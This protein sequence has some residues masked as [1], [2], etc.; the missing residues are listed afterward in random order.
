MVAQ[1]Y[2]SNAQHIQSDLQWLEKVIQQRYKTQQAKDK[3]M[4][5]PVPPPLK[6]DS[7]YKSITLEFKFTP[8]ERLV[9]VLALVPHVAPYFLDDVW[10]RIAKAGEPSH[11]KP[12]KAG[13]VPTVD[14]ALFLLAGDDLEQRFYF[15]Q[16]FD[17]ESLMRRSGMLMMENES[18][19]ISLLQQ[20]IRIS[21]DYLHLV[22][23]GKPYKPD[24]S[25]SFPAKRITT[26]R[27][28]D[29][30]VLNV[31]TLEQVMEIKSWITH[32]K[33]ILHEWELG[34]R[35]APGYKILFYGP[36]GTGKTFTAALLGRDTSVDVYRVDLSMVVSKY[37]G[38]TEKNLSRIFDSANNK[39]WILFFDEADALFGKRTELRD[40]HDRYANQ[41][42]AFLLQKIEDHNGVVILS[43]NMRANIDE[44]FTRRFQNAIYFPIPSKEERLRIWQK[45][46]S[47]KTTLQ[48]DI[49]LEQLSA[50]YEMSGGAIMNVVRYASL[51]AL[52]SKRNIIQLRDM[53]N[54]IAREFSKEGRT[55]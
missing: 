20:P 40:A 7:I 21:P 39:E 16:I 11:L 33:T 22:T 17:Q 19:D 50:R 55:I 45:G 4:K 38:E 54:G 29:D 25:T 13:T 23:D 49:S 53:V 51:K 41:E 9:L 52:E 27:T 32:G 12:V 47:L 31:N 35:L 28:W 44:A 1:H 15:Q 6:G 2:K 34:E 14:L 10:T 26:T 42:V 36:P 3:V 46:F 24:F 48:K 37:I 5:G 8:A 18:G 30:L 43:S